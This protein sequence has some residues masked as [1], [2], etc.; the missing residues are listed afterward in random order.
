MLSSPC[1]D[2]FFFLQKKARNKSTATLDKPKS[3]DS[4]ETD[5]FT[6]LDE[7]ESSSLTETDQF[8]ILDEPKSS[9]PTET[10]Q[11]TTLDKPESS[12]PA[13]TDEFTVRPPI[14]LVYS[15][16]KGRRGNMQ[17]PGKE[18]GNMGKGC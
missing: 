18:S 16:K 11:F 2:F 17:E 3:P 1:L 10:G 5:E 6:T 14:T 4:T 9:S 8:T 12:S 15:R 7:P 13:E